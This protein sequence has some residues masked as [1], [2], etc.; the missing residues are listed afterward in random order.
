MA[1]LSVAPSVPDNIVLAGAVI[2]IVVVVAA[3]GDVEP[4]DDPAGVRLLPLVRVLDDLGHHVHPPN[5]LGFRDI[6]LLCYWQ[7]NCSKVSES[8]NSDVRGFIWSS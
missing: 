3:G 7:L 6:Y 8:N 4:A 2:D 5:C 1:D